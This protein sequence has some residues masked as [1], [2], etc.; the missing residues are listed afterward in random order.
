[1]IRRPPR[2]TLFPYTTL[3][4]SR[5]AASSYDDFRRTL[6]QAGLADQV[7]VHATFSKNLARGWS[8]PIRFLWIDADHTYHGAKQDLDLFAPH[9]VAGGIVAL[10]RS[11]AH[12]SDL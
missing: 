3:F 9:L 2:S 12:T 7:E 10:Y 11:E 8:R 6:A 5:G 4:R 1:M